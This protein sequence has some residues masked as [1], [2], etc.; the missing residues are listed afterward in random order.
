MT[1]KR[2]GGILA[3]ALALGASAGIAQAAIVPGKSVA[4]VKLGD[5]Q[6]RVKAV[7]GA[8]E[9]GSNALS[10][11][12]IRSRGLGVY[13]I[14]GKAF[15]ITVVRGSQATASHIKVGSTLDAVKRA[16]PKAK[17]R[18]AVVGTNAF[19][20]ALP[21]RFGGRATETVFTVRSGR[22]KNIAVHFA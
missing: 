5:T 20:C 19:D 2:L 1:V 17:C 14:A 10:Y 22:V 11:R 12:Y 9:K 7:L 18:A 6:A 15:E 3:V 13:F 16:Y 4:G 21:A 8:P